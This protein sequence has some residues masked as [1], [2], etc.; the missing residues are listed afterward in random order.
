MTTNRKINKDESGTITTTETV[1]KNK[2][3][4]LL[5]QLRKAANH[6]YLFP[7]IEKVLIFQVYKFVQFI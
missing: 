2:L 7:G 5:A 6:P 1:V 3:M 4:S